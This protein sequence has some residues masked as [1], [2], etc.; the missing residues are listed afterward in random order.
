MFPRNGFNFKVVIKI[1]INHRGGFEKMY[2]LIRN[3][4][5]V[6]YS[7]YETT[8]ITLALYIA[9]EYGLVINVGLI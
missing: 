3:P 5:R 9:H 8:T 4:S 1:I 7:S 6:I 2:L